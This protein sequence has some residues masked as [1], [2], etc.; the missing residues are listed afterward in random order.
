[1]LFLLALGCHDVDTPFPEGMEPLEDNLASCPEGT[2]AHPYPEE[3]VLVSGTSEAFA[4]THACAYVLAPAVDTWEALQQPD[5]VVDRR[6]VAEWSATFDVEEG[7]DFSMRI[8]QLV[9][10]IIT[11][12]YDVTWRHVLVEGRTTAPEVLALRWQK[13]FGASVIDVLEGSAVVRAVDDDVTELELIEHLHAPTQGSGTIESFLTDL[14]TDVVA[15]VNGE[16]LPE[17]R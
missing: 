8:H 17:Y 5:V 1:V 13:T 3:I 15:W 7:Y 11:V 2:G 9:R 6:R 16:E 4:W 12:E 10:D 14:H